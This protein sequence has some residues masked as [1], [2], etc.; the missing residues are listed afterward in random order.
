MNTLSVWNPLRELEDLQNRLSTFF[1]HTPIENGG[2]KDEKPLLAQWSPVVDI[3][4]DDK[5]FIIKAELPEIKK[6]DVKVTV[7]DGVLTLFGE[8]K[9]EMEDKGVRHHRI[10]RSYG[11]FLRSFSLPEAADDKGI[12][13][14]Y[15]NGVLTI[16]LPKN[17]RLEPKAIEVAVK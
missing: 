11:S 6:E 17:P 16:H 8:R 2:N 7:S 14:K 15:D 1:R 3:S 9:Q 4:E 13:A 5:E 12:A 10:E